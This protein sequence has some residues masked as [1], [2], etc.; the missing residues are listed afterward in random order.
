MQTFP[1]MT[2]GDF[3]SIFFDMEGCG[4]VNMDMELIKYLI[5]LFK[6]YY[7]F[8]LNYIIIYEMAWILS[9]NLFNTILASNKPNRCS[10]V[11]N[12]QKL[13]A[14]KGNRKAENRI[15]KGC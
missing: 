10:C 11:Q 2:K 3:I 12:R 7:P 5:G 4:L 8:F 15:E 14:R 9:G 6:D 13:A 1:R